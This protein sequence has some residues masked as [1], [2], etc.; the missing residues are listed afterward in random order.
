MAPWPVANGRR[1]SPQSFTQVTEARKLSGTYLP[2]APE[3][4]GRPAWTIGGLDAKLWI[5]L[6]LRGFGFRACL[7]EQKRFQLSHLHSPKLLA[8]LTWLAFPVCC[9]TS[10]TSS[11]LPLDD[12]L[13]LNILKLH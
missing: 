7:G 13:K 12:G 6:S 10:N 2:K 11:L 5:D 8:F 4:A 1:S 9:F 3:V